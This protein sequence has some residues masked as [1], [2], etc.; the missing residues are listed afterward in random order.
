MTTST[1]N[2]LKTRRSMLEIDA[3]GQAQYGGFWTDKQRRHQYLS[4]LYEPLFAPYRDQP[5]RLLE[6]GSAHGG[7]LTLWAEWFD[8]VELVG[9]DIHPNSANGEFIPDMAQPKYS[10]FL[11]NYCCDGF[12]ADRAQELGQFDI[13]IEDAEHSQRQ[14]LQTIELYWP[15]VR[16][17]GL[18]VIE[19]IHSAVSRDVLVAAL[20]GARYSWHDFRSY[21]GTDDSQCLVVYKD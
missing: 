16:K 13:I 19:D 2:T 11:V 18:L 12:T 3:W 20:A 9:C 6:L 21:T 5:Q 17:G 10:E 4:R 7:S 14:M 1:L 8:S 15:S